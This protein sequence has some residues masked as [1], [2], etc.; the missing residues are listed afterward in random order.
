MTTAY[1]TQPSHVDHHMPDHPER[2][3]RLIAVERAMVAVAPDE[4]LRLD[5]L[6]A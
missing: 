1:F 4:R 6:Y 2:A 5:V 3:D